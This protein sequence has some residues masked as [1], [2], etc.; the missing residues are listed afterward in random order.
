MAEGQDDNVDQF[1][2]SVIRSFLDNIFNLMIVIIE[3]KK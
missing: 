2:L 1:F 3:G